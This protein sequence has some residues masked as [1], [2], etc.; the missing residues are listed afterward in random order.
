MKE[1]IRVDKK[2][3]EQL[4]KNCKLA[5]ELIARL[6]YIHQ[7]FVLN[8]SQDY[9]NITFN[10]KCYK[11]GTFYEDLQTWCL[12]LDEIQLICEVMRTYHFTSK[13]CVEQWEHVL[14]VAKELDWNGGEEPD[15]P[16]C[17]HPNSQDCQDCK[18]YIDINDSCAIGAK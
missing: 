15:E 17:L 6:F 1:R 12:F 8:L 5:M 10:V 4:E 11:K 14:K 16:E 13:H 3:F 7:G 18:M 2:H 9:G